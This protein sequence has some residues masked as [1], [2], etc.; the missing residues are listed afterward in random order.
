MQFRFVCGR[1]GFA[2]ALAGGVALSISGAVASQL[3]DALKG[4]WSG[5]GEITLANGKSEKIRCHGE[6]RE[7]SENAV[8]Q[9]F[10]CASTDK[11]F[12]FSTSMHFSEGRARGNWSAP[13]RN[14]TLSGSASSGSLQLHLSSSSG[15]GNLSASIGSCSQSINVTGWSDELK[16]LSANLKKDC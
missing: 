9:F 4:R 16:S 3:T 5:S 12:D 15:E 1:N 2:V 11:V 13:D 8:E 6:S 7:V 10:H 14:G